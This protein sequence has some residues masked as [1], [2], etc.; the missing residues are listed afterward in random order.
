[1]L[2]DD[3]RGRDQLDHYVATPATPAERDWGALT[4]RVVLKSSGQQSG[5]VGT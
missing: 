1:M 5:E 3:W 2:G 4:P